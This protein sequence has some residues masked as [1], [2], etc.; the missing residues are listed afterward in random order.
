MTLGNIGRVDCS[1]GFISLEKKAADPTKLYVS[2]A[3]NFSQEPR[4]ILI[5][6][7]DENTVRQIEIT[8]NTA[9]SYEVLE[10]VVQETANS[11]Q[12]N[13][14]RLSGKTI[15]NNTSNPITINTSI[16]EFFKE[17]TS[18]S[19]FTSPIIGTFEYVPSPD[20]LITM[21]PLVYQGVNYWDEK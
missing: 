17:V 7:K 13:T 6:I 10:K 9:S 14:V 12:I 2:M 4:R 1:R 18:T 15:V 16:R 19:E 3:E 5:G 8:Q 11:L 21:I 20:S